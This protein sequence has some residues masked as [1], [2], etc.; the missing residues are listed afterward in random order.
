LQANGIHVTKEIPKGQYE[1][2]MRFGFVSNSSSQSF[3]IDMKAYPT[4]FDLALHML[5]IRNDDYKDYDEKNKERF[6]SEEVHCSEERRIITSERD[7]NTSVSFSSC[8]FDT[9]ITCVGNA[10]FVATCNNHPFHVHLNGRL[11]LY[12]ATLN[13]DWLKETFKDEDIE[14]IEQDLEYEIEKRFQQRPF[15]WPRYDLVLKIIDY[16]DKRHDQFKCRDQGH[17]MSPYIIAEGQYT[18]KIVCPH[19]FI[20]RG[21]VQGEA[22]KADLQKMR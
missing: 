20:E 22:T 15:W 12:D 16:E 13:C 11:N 8:N 1:M 6:F 5:E 19:C 10:F 14:G 18:G 9:E 3:L 4:V 2:K 21:V 7:R 17:W